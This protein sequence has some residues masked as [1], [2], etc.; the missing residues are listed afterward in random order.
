M[1]QKSFKLWGGRFHKPADKLA[2]EFTESISFDSRLYRHDILGS[3][4]HVKMLSK[5]GLVPKN[6]AVRIVS[7]LRGLE[8]EISKRVKAGRFKLDKKY[9]DI[10]TYIE[11]KVIEKVGDA[12]GSK[13]HTA[14]SRN[15]Q[16]SVDL[17]LYIKDEIREILLLLSGVCNVILDNAKKYRDVLMPGYTHMQVAKPIYFRDYIL[18]Y[19]EM[20]YRDSQRLLDCLKR[21]DFSPL[22]AG[23]I[24]GTFYKKTDRASVA[25]YLG[26]SGVVSNT[27]DAVSDRD[28][29]IEFIFDLAMITLHIS[30][31]SEDF[32]IWLNPQFGFISLDES[33]MTG[34]SIL[35][36]KKNPDVC[37]I[38]RAKTGRLYGNLMT[39]LTLMKGLPLSYNR[40]MQEDKPPL[41]DSADTVKSTLRIYT[42]MLEKLGVNKQKMLEVLV[43]ASGY[44]VAPKMVDYLAEKGFSLRKAH[45]FVSNLVKYCEAKKINLLSLKRPDLADFVNNFYKPDKGF[46]GYLVGRSK[47][48]SARKA[49]ESAPGQYLL[50]EWFNEK[51]LKECTSLSLPAV[52]KNGDRQFKDVSERIRGIMNETSAYYK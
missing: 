30:R 37:E 49:A 32:V 39:L 13:I 50:E 5:C 52:D 27:V 44:A 36:Q 9:E 42:K 38:A 41:F 1:T 19:F 16:V 18:A 33:F 23:A 4:A 45:G 29:V 20:F 8:K 51:F 40:D 46:V 7:A 3:V 31:I 43:E 2:E 6:E 48:G 14:R 21:M 47:A 28:F 10:H 34:S 11:K 35:P 25:R 26:F 24:G 15:D 12:I 22:G 17:R